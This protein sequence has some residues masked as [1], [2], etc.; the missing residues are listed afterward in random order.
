MKIKRLII[1]LF[2]VVIGGGFG[3]HQLRKHS[4]FFNMVFTPSDWSV[5][6]ATSAID[7]GTQGQTYTLNFENKYPGLHWLEVRVTKP[8]T[9]SD[10][11]KSDFELQLEMKYG[12]KLIVSE[13]IKGP[14][15]SFSGSEKG[16]EIFWYRVPGKLPLRKPIEAK[17]TILKSDKNFASIYGNAELA[18]RKLSDE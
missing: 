13:V 4:R 9:I 6:L 16:F 2:I 12:E 3:V 18:I 11:Y 17:I 14:G 8:I 10:K 1:Y 15:S 7:F 5:P